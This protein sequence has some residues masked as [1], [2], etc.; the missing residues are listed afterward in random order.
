M[1]GLLI[2]LDIGSETRIMIPGGADMSVSAQQIFHP[3]N[4]EPLVKKYWMVL[5]LVIT[6]LARAGSAMPASLSANN[7]AAND[8]RVTYVGNAGFL[9]TVG[10]RKIL[11][12]PMPEEAKDALEN[13]RPPFNDV[14]LILI[15]HNHGDH[16]NAPMIRQ[17]LKTMPG[18][19]L[20]STAQVTG[21]LAEFGNRIITLAATKEKRDQTDVDGIQVQAIYLSHGTPPAGRE[22]SVNFGYLVTADTIRLF[23]TGDIDLSL[24]DMT[25]P[26]SPGKRIDLAFIA[27]F[28]FSPDPQEQKFVKEWVNGRF[29]IPIHLKLTRPAFDADQIKLIK[30]NYPD[31]FLF[32]KELQSWDMPASA[33]K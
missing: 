5:L 3:L 24:V 22:E 12:D 19:R 21:Q 32:E 18:A 7:T 26:L 10:N 16:F 15:T 8:V 27:H 17:L 4:K 31:A 28:F 29:A 13:A 11:I 33:R 30:A 2:V 1:E 6:L 9:I 20:I 25:G 14:D 23:H